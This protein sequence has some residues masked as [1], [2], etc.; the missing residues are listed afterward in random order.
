MYAAVSYNVHVTVHTRTCRHVHVHV[1]VHTRT[2]R[3]VH[4]HVTVHVR[5]WS[6]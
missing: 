6:F 2:C 4:V 3:H 1:T 5:T